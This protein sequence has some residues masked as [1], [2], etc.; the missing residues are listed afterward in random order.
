MPSKAYQDFVIRAKDQFT[1]PMKRMDKSVTRFS[2]NS[3]RSFRGVGDSLRRIRGLVGG[4]AAAMTAGA[5]ARGIGQ[6]AEAGDEIGKTARQLGIGVEALQELRFAAERQGVSTDNLE[7][8]FKAMNNRLG[9]L[10]S[11]QG[12]LST[13]LERTNP[14]LLNQLKTTTDS[15]EAFMLL[16][17]AMN[18]ASSAAE[19]TAL[20]QAAFSSS[21]RELVR[22][23]EA[24]SGGIESLREEARASG[25]VMSQEATQAA[26]KFQDSMT[27]LRSAAMGLRNRALGPLI[28]ELTPLI[29]QTSAWIRENKELISLKME[30]VFDKIRSTVR[31]LVKAWDSGLIPAI[32]AG[33][34]AFKAL[35]TAIAVVNSLKVAWAAFNVVFIA[36]PIGAIVAGV[37]ALAG[38]LVLLW[39]R[40]EKFRN[41]IK[42]VWENIKRIATAGPRLLGRLGKFLGIG[43]G[44][45]PAQAGAGGGPGGGGPR[46]FG[47]PVEQS[48]VTENR[49]TVDVNLAGL[50]Q[51]SSVRQKGQAPGVTLN[52]A[53]Q[54][55]GL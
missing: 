55:A 10:R 6:F 44:G 48:T 30:Q 15:E 31:L 28:E 3:R 5:V 32:L 8:S 22:V 12:Q 35:N 39:K 42:A 46:M 41:T 33:V 34:A 38:L 11:G 47:R 37:A 43:G 23:A 2:R 4:V 13:L 53:Y 40:S 49:S 16:M 51:G 19:R 24:G 9:L 36:T 17:D 7:K 1:R 29:S 45:A 14:Q 27:N 26:E 54:G 52:T 18:G 25:M 20:A 50:P 21:G